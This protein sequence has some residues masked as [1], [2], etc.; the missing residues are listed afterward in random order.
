MKLEIAGMRSTNK[1]CFW[2]GENIKFQVDIDDVKRRTI[3]RITVEAESKKEALKK[4]V[5]E[6]GINQVLFIEQIEEN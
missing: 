5:E 2:E 1:I 4:A 6:T 3:V